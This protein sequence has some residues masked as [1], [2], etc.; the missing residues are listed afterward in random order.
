MEY[1]PGLF[2]KCLPRFPLMMDYNLELEAV[3]DPFLPKVT[4]GQVFITMTEMKVK[5]SV[6]GLSHPCPHA[7]P[8][9]FAVLRMEHTV[10][11]HRS[12][13]DLHHIYNFCNFLGI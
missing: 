4:S 9:P 3:R 12:T 2:L 13:T 5:H 1:Q 11:S 8:R 6:K 7:R 10:A